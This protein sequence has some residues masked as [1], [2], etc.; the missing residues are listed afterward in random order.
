M[1]QNWPRRWPTVSSP[2]EADG[3]STSSPVVDSGRRRWS[4]KRPGPEAAMFRDAWLMTAKDLRIEARARIAMWQVL[5]FAIL[6]LI[7]FAF[8][9]GPDADTLRRA[10][11]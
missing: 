9:L 7:L 11:P 2:W 6:V 1:S 3:W 4:S 10:A 5:P 8:A